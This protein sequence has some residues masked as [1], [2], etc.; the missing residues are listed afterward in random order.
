MKRKKENLKMLKK[1]G[2]SM[3]TLF[4]YKVYVIANYI[5]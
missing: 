3:F 1:N 5:S 2:M 4:N